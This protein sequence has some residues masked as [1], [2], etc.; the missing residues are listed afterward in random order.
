MDVTTLS[1]K[2]CD[3]VKVKGRIDSGT[4]PKVA[5]SITKITDAGHFRLVIDLSEVDFISSAGL[6]ILISTQKTC[7]R[8][9]RGEVLLSGVG[10]KIH[11]AL[12]LAGFLG[13][14]KIHKDALT[15]VGSF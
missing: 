6:R 13:L 15:A 4:A 10:P 14:F 9:N 1:F 12:D 8:F 3:L 5:E 7:R 11:S 2:H